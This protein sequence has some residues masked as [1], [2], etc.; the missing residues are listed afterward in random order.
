MALRLGTFSSLYAAGVWDFSH[1]NHAE[2]PRYDRRRYMEFGNQLGQTFSD[3][4][5]VHGKHTLS[6]PPPEPASPGSWNDTA[7]FKLRSNDIAGLKL[8]DL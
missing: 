5:R 7:V 2:H 6:T 4:Y 8:S 1:S 3:Y